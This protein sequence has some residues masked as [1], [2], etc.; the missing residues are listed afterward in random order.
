MMQKNWKMIETLAQE[1]SSE[2]TQWELFNEYWH[3]RVCI[4]FLKSFASLIV[5]WTRVASALEGLKQE[6]Q[7]MNIACENGVVIY[8]GWGGGGG[9]GFLEETGM[10]HTCVA[11]SSES[12][13]AGVL[14]G[15]ES[16]QYSTNT[17]V[18]IP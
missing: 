4:S 9:G 11:A 15:T 7:P 3:G 5:L 6:K 18:G 13:M 16:D 2:S 8:Q 17:A 1:Y 12:V 10:V 14:A